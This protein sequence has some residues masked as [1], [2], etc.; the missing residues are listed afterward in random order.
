[1]KRA[2][3]YILIGVFAVIF[4]ISAWNLGTYFWEGSQSQAQYDDLAQRV[5]NAKNE[6]QPVVYFSVPT[7]SSNEEPS[8]S[9]TQASEDAADRPV[10]SESTAPTDP[11]D[12]TII[13]EY[14]QLYLDNPDLVGWIQIEGTTLNYPVV[15][16]PDS[17]DYY[18][19]RNF[20]K[21][22]SSRGCI[23]VDED[24]D[25][26]APSDN[27]TIYGHH[28][29]DGSMF[30]TLTRYSSKSYLAAH[31]YITFNTLLEKNTYE[32]IAV[33]TTT[34]SLGEG[35]RYNAFVDAATAEEFDEYVATCKKLSLYKIEATAVY[36][37]KLI[38][39]STCEYTQE[40][41]RFVVVAKLIDTEQIDSQS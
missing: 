13:P 38:T 32:I 19:K 24:C 40:N 7:K 14:A 34:A 18:L 8:G 28:M 31:P 30:T 1:M 17:K 39:L 27:I 36:G 15:Q 3:Y 5:E 22:Y 20:D 11:T 37:D 25:V 9:E 33:F 12:P 6:E 21:E 41:G 16:T 4:I 2:I 23:Y 35:F 29:R 26:F 10:S